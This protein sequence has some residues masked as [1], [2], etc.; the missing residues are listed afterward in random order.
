MGEQERLLTV[1]GGVCSPCWLSSGCLC[2]SRAALATAPLQQARPHLAIPGGLAWPGGWGHGPAVAAGRWFSFS[3][4]GLVLFLEWGKSAPPR[5]CQEAIRIS[6]GRGGQR[7]THPA[8]DP[9]TQILLRGCGRWGVADTAGNF[10]EGH[11][12][13]RT[14]TFWG[15][16]LSAC[17]L[18]VSKST[19]QTILHFPQNGLPKG[20]PVVLP[21]SQPLGPKGLQAGSSGREKGRRGSSEAASPG[22]LLACLFQT[23]RNPMN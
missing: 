5:L 23:S 6:E 14:S 9:H 7:V 16:S 12:G 15:T 18:L 21:R 22:H 20:Q 17:L 1:R 11:L 2:Q 8:G 3:T 10:W 4:R 13:E 19:G